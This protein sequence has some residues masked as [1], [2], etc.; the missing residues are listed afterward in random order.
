MFPSDN[1]SILLPDANYTYDRLPIRCVPFNWIF[2]LMFNWD[3]R[4]VKKKILKKPKHSICEIIRNL[5]PSVR[6]CAQYNLPFWTNFVQNVR[7]LFFSN[8]KMF[9]R[10]FDK[11]FVLHDSSTYSTCIFKNVNPYV[12]ELYF[13]NL[14]RDELNIFRFT[15]RKNKCFIQK[16]LTKKSIR[17]CRNR[18][19]GC[20]LNIVSCVQKPKV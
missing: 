14:N 13:W 3:F 5:I 1:T 10:R 11:K 9:K 7:F 15:I 18:I 2:Q 4:F 6:A 12:A 17:I 20:H 19:G 16:P 8:L